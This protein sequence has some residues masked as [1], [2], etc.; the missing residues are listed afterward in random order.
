MHMLGAIRDRL[1]ELDPEHAADYARN[2]DAYLAELQ[3]LDRELVAADYLYQVKRLAFSP[4]HSPVA[5]LMAEHIRGF[6]D[7]AKRAKA[8]YTAL[9][10][11]DGEPMVIRTLVEA[12]I[13][14]FDVASPAEFRTVRDI[15]PARDVGLLTAWI[16]RH[17]QVWPG[18]LEAADHAMT[19]LEELP[20]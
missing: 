12:G 10:R 7:F 16:N 13:D 19:T 15:A 9:P 6:A 14:V 5:S 4:N 3:A 1:R 2:H 17:G 11:V 20:L 8:A 18:E